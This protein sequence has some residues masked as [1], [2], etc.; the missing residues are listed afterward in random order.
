MMSAARV[1]TDEEQKP[2]R[3]NDERKK[4]EPNHT[5]KPTSFSDTP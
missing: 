1:P 3:G 2:E 4:N 5:R